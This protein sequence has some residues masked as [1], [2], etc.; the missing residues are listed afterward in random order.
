LTDAR[1]NTRDFA[2]VTSWLT[3][4][5]RFTGLIAHCARGLIMLRLAY[6]KHPRA[7]QLAMVRQWS[8]RLLTILG[9]QLRVVPDSAVVAAPCMGVANHVS[10]LDPFVI[11][12]SH[13]ARFVAK[14]EIRGWPFI[15]ALCAMAG[16]L[17]IER[18]KRTDAHRINAML[19]EALGAGDFVAVFP[20]GT[21]SEGDMVR[22]F[23]GNLLQAA[24]DRGLPLQ[25][26]TLRYLN[27]DG[28]R[29]IAAAH[30]GEQTLAASVL[31]VLS[32]TSITVELTLLP[33]IA[34]QGRSRRE[35][36]QLAEAAIAGALNLPVVHKRSALPGGPPA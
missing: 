29:C 10:W 14:A 20:E 1:D 24:I 11:D 36:A 23:H 35:L 34:T 13:P 18:V 9:I 5:A 22:Y 4:L 25:P 28:S 3:R 30:V 27:P 26:M 31:Q 6:P 21:T 15:G 2:P 33:V 7:E 16:T 17:F 8:R 32:R 12:A 19:S